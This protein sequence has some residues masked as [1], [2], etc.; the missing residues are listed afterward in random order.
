M[1][2]PD[3]LKAVISEDA[4]RHLVRRGCEVSRDRR[5]VCPECGKPVKDLDAV[6][7]RIKAKKDLITCQT[8]NEKV[9]L[10]DFIEQRLKSDPVARKILAMDATATRKLDTQALEKILIDHMMAIAD[11]ANQIFR[12]VTMFDHGIDGE[13]ESERVFGNAS[14]P[15]FTAEGGVQDGEFEAVGVGQTHEVGVGHI[16]ARGEWGQG[17]GGNG[18]FQEAMRFELDDGAQ[19]G[20][21]I[22]E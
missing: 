18:V 13:V 1:E 19:G 15:R 20:L 16:F 10:M 6:R 4:H 12:P 2:V 17:V 11:E 3:E 21:G 14:G 7:K 9:P 5:Y 22:G 8:C